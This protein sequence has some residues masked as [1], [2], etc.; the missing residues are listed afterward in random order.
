MHSAAQAVDHG[1]DVVLFHEELLV[2]YV[3]DPRA[4]AEPVDGTTTRQF[5]EALRGTRTRV[6]Y[7]LTERDGQDHYIAAVVVGSEGIVGH[8][9]KTHLWW[10]ASG[11]RY[12][13]GF[14]RPGDHW[15]TFD[16]GRFRAG[17]MI[18]Y[19]GD[20]P[21]TTRSY[22]NLGCTMLFWMNNR[23]SRGFEEVRD[24]ARLNSIIIATSCCCGHDERMEPC[25][26]GSN[27]VD[28]GGNLLAEIW[29]TEGIIYADV[30]PEDVLTLRQRNPW[31]VGQRR[32]LYR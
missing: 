12:E 22:A 19:D 20:F 2:G 26:G 15:T 9:R 24:K 4:L 27:I 32:D 18:C 1:A 8:Y 5:Q 11:A 29:D 16:L 17:V 30:S 25:R 23:G 3:E 14:Y 31:F 6:L 28:A 7:G 10:D 21:E 13:P